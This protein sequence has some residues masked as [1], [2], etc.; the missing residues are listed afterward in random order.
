MKKHNQI[1]YCIPFLLSFILYLF[2]SCSEAAKSNDDSLHFSVGQW[3]FHEE[4]FDSIMNNFEF[5][6][7]AAEL[8]FNGV[9]YV[10]QFFIDKARDFQFLD[11]L[12]KHATS[13]GLTNSMLLVDLAG[14]L[15]AS[16]EAERLKAL[17][18]HK[19][20]VIACSKLA[21]PAMRIN[22]HGDGSPDSIR[23]QGLKS[24]KILAPFADSNSVKILIENHGG[25]S[26]DADWLLDMIQS[27]DH[28]N[29]GLVVD[30]DNWCVVY[31]N[32]SLWGKN[33]IQEYP[34]YEGMQKLLPFADN[35]SVKAFV[36]DTY[37]EDSKTDFKQMAQIIDSLGF[38][39][40]FGIEYEGDQLM[41]GQGAVKT[42]Q[43]ISKH[44]EAISSNQ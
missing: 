33:C 17:E 14:N 20:W 34:R 19:E 6:D 35:I 22:M 31:E 24:L 16:S 9:E 37:G 27:L 40:S 8:E 11:A 21:C 10:N 42:R 4:L 25:I 41:P 44:L 5:V 39:G 1:N 13:K 43:L 29:V 12:S 38:E 18:S 26:N 36:F 3:T 30:F 32:G 2:S 7:K 28:P 23:E 15:A